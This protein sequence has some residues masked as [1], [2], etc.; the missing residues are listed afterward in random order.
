VS[1]RQ[2]DK[3]RKEFNAPPFKAMLKEEL[4]CTCVNCGS[5]KY[6]EYHHIVPV[7]YGGTNKLTNIVPLCIDCHYKAH[8]KASAEGMKKA[9]DEGRCGRNKITTYEA[10]KPVLKRYFNLEIGN[11]ELHEI[12]GFSPTNHSGTYLFKQKYRKEFK[13]PKGFRNNIDLLAAMP[14]R[15]Y[16]DGNYGRPSKAE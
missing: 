12:L 1:Q 10:A 9:K 15:I 3:I 6:I 13:T 2:F 8:S 5:K 11:R 7:V 16:K 14:K 4:G